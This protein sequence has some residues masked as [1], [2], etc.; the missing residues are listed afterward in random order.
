LAIRREVL[1]DQ[2]PDTA[3]SLN[4]LGGLLHN[5][6]DYAGARPYYEQALVV[7]CET[8]GVQHPTTI[9]TQLNL[10]ILYLR[11][12]D[13]A[14]AKGLLSEAVVG[15]KDLPEGHPSRTMVFDILRQ[16]GIED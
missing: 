8:L 10:I 9:Q 12:Q 3:T 5:M 16:L 2:H 11:M 13:S 6:G 1:G 14:S 7:L 4:N 15:V